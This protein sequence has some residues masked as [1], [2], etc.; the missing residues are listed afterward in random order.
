MGS[1]EKAEVGNQLA[2][3]EEKTRVPNWSEGKRKDNS[4]KEG[5]IEEEIGVKNRKEP[6]ELPEG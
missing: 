1:E 4:H 5:D 2:E 6:P 3:G